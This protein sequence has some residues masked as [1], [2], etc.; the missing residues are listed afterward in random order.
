MKYP[1]LYSIAFV[2]LQILSASAQPG[3]ILQKMQQFNT[4]A[5]VLYI[6]AHPDDENTRLISYLVNSRHYRTAYLS[7]TRGDGGQNL[8][9]NEQTEEL[10]LIRTQELLAA[11]GQDGGEQYFTR[12]FDFGYSKNPEETFAI[13]NAQEV[14]SNSE[15]YVKVKSIVE[16]KAQTQPILADVVWVIRNFRP[17]IIVTRFPTTG[18]GGHGHHTASAMLALEA[19]E[20]A[21]DPNAFPNQLQY[22]QPWKTKRIFWNNFMRWRDPEADMSGALALEINDYLPELGKSIG[23]IAAYSRSAHRSQGFGS[24]PQYDNLTEYFSLMAGDEAKTDIM[25]GVVSDWSRIPGGNGLQV[26]MQKAIKEFENLAPEKSIPLLTKLKVELDALPDFPEKKYKQNQLTEIILACAGMH[27]EFNAEKSEANPGSKINTD[28]EI[29]LRANVPNVSLTAVIMSG[30]TETS[31]SAVDEIKQGTQLKRKYEISLPENASFTNPYWLEKPHLLGRFDVDNQLEIGQADVTDAIS[32]NVRFII[33]E[34][35]VQ[36]KLP[37][38][39]RWVDPSRGQLT[40]PFVIVPQTQARISPELSVL[41]GTDEKVIRVDLQGANL[42]GAKIS[43]DVPTSIFQVEP[44]EFII[45][46]DKPL[47]SIN[48]KVKVSN[49][50]MF[51]PD[52]AWD[53]NVMLEKDGKRDKIKSLTSI[54]YEHIPEQTWIK[55]ASVK[56]VHLN[57]VKSG[58]QI[59]YLEG[60]GDKVDECLANA[61]YQVHMLNDDE[62][63]LSFLQEFDAVV[64]GIRAFNT[65]ED[66]EFVMPVLLK[67]VEEG[68]NVIVQYNTKNWISDVAIEPGPYPIT[69]SRDRVTDEKAIMTMLNP[70]HPVMTSPNLITEKDFDGWIQER[71]LYFPDKW[72]EKYEALLACADPKEKECQGILLATEYGKGKFM[73]TGLSFFRELP[74]GVPGAYRLFANMIAWGNEAE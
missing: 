51:K 63:R 59:A 49:N 8:I 6:A 39:Y 12:A 56:L 28:L 31:D 30:S 61:G 35:P 43:L 66:M 36:V 69:I 65:R 24:K 19:F 50:R 58:N 32:A 57:L 34:T 70:K 5:N 42:K 18:E 38:R 45:D 11:R 55:E 40:K 27:I 60:A 64:V 37:L 44:A 62:I 14:D 4:V 54:K 67:Y 74:A 47:H 17:D 13:W 22:V 21:A 7:M 20:L 16:N 9:G 73:Y 25:E 72:S 68:G 15:S 46:E 2:F 41:S 26:G 1:I 33:N 48:F 52:K 29:T 3:E 10:G 53:V 71:G 23:E